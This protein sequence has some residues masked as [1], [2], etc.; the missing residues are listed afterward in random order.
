MDKEINIKYV[1]IKSEEL[2]N[3]WQLKA[4]RLKIF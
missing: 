3:I 1:S 2:I 4:I